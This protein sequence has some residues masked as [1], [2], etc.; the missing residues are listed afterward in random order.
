[1][2]WCPHAGRALTPEEVSGHVLR[3]LVDDAAAHLGE[4]VGVRPVKGAERVTSVTSLCR[5]WEAELPTCRAGL[6]L[7]AGGYLEMSLPTLRKSLWH[8]LAHALSVIREWNTGTMVWRGPCPLQVDKAVVSVPVYFNDVQRHAT[9]AAG[10]AAGLQVGKL[11]PEPSLTLPSLDARW[12]HSAPP[13]RCGLRCLP[14]IP[15]PVGPAPHPRV[16]HLTHI[17]LSPSF[18]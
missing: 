8:A 17:H 11:A 13:C 14:A 10:K 3:K 15:P 6:V 2:L 16:C 18:S 5:Q 7:V 4:Q 12:V 1:M 9:K